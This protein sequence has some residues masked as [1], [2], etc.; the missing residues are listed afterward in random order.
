[1]TASLRR[2]NDSKGAGRGIGGFF[3]AQLVRHLPAEENGGHI[4]KGWHGPWEVKPELGSLPSIEGL[5]LPRGCLQAVG[6]G[7]ASQLSLTRCWVRM[8]DEGTWGAGGRM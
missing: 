5:H 8:G 4:Y 7:T 2:V 6:D 1:M 3:A